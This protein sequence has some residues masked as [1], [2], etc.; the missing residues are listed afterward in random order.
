[1]ADEASG[2]GTGTGTGT[3]PLLAWDAPQMQEQLGRY[4]DEDEDLFV[5]LGSDG[6]IKDGLLDYGDAEFSFGS[7]S[8]PQLAS[9]MADASCAKELRRDL[10]M[11]CYPFTDKAFWLPANL[12]P[13]CTLEA[14]AMA[15]FEEHTQ[16]VGSFDR[17][18]S[19]VEWWAQ[20]R[21]PGEDSESIGFH[22]DKDEQLNTAV[23][24]LF[25]QPQIACVT[26]LSDCGAPTCV[27]PI[28]PQPFVSSGGTRGGLPSPDE[29]D[30]GAV[31]I[32]HPR[33]GKRETRPASH[34]RRLPL[35][36]ACDGT[37]SATASSASLCQTCGLMAGSCTVR[38]HRAASNRG[39]RRQEARGRRTRRATL[40]CAT[41]GCTI[42]QCVRGRARRLRSRK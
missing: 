41:C 3:L 27:V 13:R 31:H 14:M 9:L 7:W 26:Y 40:S 38:R 29:V 33:V 17:A 34:R 28:V 37:H 42:G 1:M 24:G 22:W 39:S 2:S 25:V 18:R 35:P 30:Q 23:D 20:I 32:S 36:L 6:R 10:L 5:A 12:Q 19:G 15:I 16:G 8:M 11:C 21:R 4:E